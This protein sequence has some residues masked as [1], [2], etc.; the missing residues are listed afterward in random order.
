MAITRIGFVPLSPGLHTRINIHT[1]L[2]QSAMTNATMQTTTTPA[3]TRRGGEGSTDDASVGGANPFGKE[4]D[5]CASCCINFLNIPT[6]VSEASWIAMG[7]IFQ[8]QY[9]K[10]VAVRNSR[11][12]NCILHFDALRRR[13][14]SKL[15][16]YN[17]SKLTEAHMNRETLLHSANCLS[18]LDCIEKRKN[19]KTKKQKNRKPQKPKEKTSL[20]LKSN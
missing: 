10:S 18:L 9:K 2:Q 13:Q 19:K 5:A 8:G 7:F 16:N 4:R 14:A 15:S 17:K 20:L 1:A 11:G 6:R 3:A 12:L